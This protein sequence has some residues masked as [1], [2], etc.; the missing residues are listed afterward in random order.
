MP[1]V[2][3]QVTLL[4]SGQTILT[5]FTGNLQNRALETFRKTGVNVRL[6]VRVTEIT[7][8]EV[9][10]PLSLSCCTGAG[11]ICLMACLAAPSTAMP[12]TLASLATCTKQL[13]TF[14]DVFLA[15]DPC[16][17]GQHRTKDYCQLRQFKL[18]VFEPLP[19]LCRSYLMMKRGLSMG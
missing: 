13:S 12:N 7:E 17:S 15:R 4:Q 14:V 19:V 9:P 10:V 11:K 1:R 6:G 8:S 16:R 18:T 3:L 2:M 5:T